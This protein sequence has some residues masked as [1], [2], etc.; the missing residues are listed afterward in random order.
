MLVSELFVKNRQIDEI[1]RIEPWDYEGGKED[2]DYSFT[3][4]R[5]RPLPGGSGLLYSVKTDAYNG[6]V[7]K[8]WD[9]KGLDP[10]IALLAKEEGRP[11]PGLLIGQMI[12]RRS[13][14]PFPRAYR[15]D[16][17]N[18]DEDYRKLGIG[19]SLYGIALSQLGMTLIA[20]DSQTPGGRRAWANLWR[21]S[22]ELPLEVRGYLSVTDLDL[23]LGAVST[24]P[25][26][27]D[28]EEEPADRTHLVDVLMGSL[29]ADYIGKYRGRHY[30]AFDVRPNITGAELESQ[31]R[32]RY[33][34]IYGDDF[35]DWDNDSVGLYARWHGAQGQ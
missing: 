3:S 11:L 19:R 4:K 14:L 12:V 21:M 26:S 27:Y 6:T 2:L 17:V 18:V 9:P 5:V 22:Q 7:I 25:P 31:V 13:R 15:V 10:K 1:V 34:E 29:G 20:G 8:I 32:T 33:T 23:E 30:F 16:T 35:D 28:R 24:A